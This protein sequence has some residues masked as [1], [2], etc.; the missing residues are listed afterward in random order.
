MKH[1]HAVTK[2]IPVKASGLCGFK[3]IF[4]SI[5]SQTAGEFNVKMNRK[6]C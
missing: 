4:A 2:Q 6:G 5:T 3:A 1:V